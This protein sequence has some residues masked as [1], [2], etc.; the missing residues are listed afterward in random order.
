MTTPVRPAGWTTGTE[1]WSRMRVGT[2]GRPRPGT[3]ARTRDRG[4]TITEIVI[5]V[6]LLGIVV[7]GVLNA[8]MT[9]IR[10][11]STSR[12][13]ARV[14]TAIV[15]AA[16]RINRAPKRCSY[17]MFA[18]AA[19][20]TEGWDESHA[21]TVLSYW[22]AETAKWLTG[23]GCGASTKPPDLIVQKV[24]VR[25]TSPDGTV[26]RTIEVVKSDV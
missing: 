10:A 20:L 9:G 25:I 21:E 3:V 17:E 2:D 15:N 16:D 4:F 12:Q 7:A 23:H 13:A 19:V 14:E 6:V 26:A 24:T 5:T 18:D 22:D 1:D 11:S 8:V